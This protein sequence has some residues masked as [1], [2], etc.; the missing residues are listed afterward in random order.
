M[1]SINQGVHG[2]EKSQGIFSMSGNFDISQGILHF[3]QKVMEESW[4]FERHVYEL[5]KI[6]RIPP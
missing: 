4:N 1:L 6:S 5:Q 2:Q 3:Q